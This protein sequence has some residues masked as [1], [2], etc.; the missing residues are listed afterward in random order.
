M[1]PQYR[2]PFLTEVIAR[3]DFVSEIDLEKNKLSTSSLENILRTFPI[4]EPQEAV[5]KSIS[6]SKQ[7]TEARDIIEKHLYYHGKMREKVLG[8]TPKAAFIKYT[9]YGS[10]KGLE[11]DF[12]ILLTLLKKEFELSANRFGLRYINQIEIEGNNPL[13]WETYIHKALLSSIS[14]VDDP[15]F[16][17][18]VF[19]SMIQKYDDDM[20]LNFQYGI[21]NPSFPSRIKKKLYILDYD[22][23]YQGVLE[24][25]Y[26]KEG[27]KSAHDRIEDLFEKSICTSLRKIMEKI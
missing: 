16:L 5:S 14:M 27:I 18:R 25:E 17:A 21:H 9:T 7:G 22:A 1:C 3:I 8:I 10:F 20:L 6:I 11:N 2:K 24:L 13:N 19:S 12:S 4:P 26:L 23:Y 15:S